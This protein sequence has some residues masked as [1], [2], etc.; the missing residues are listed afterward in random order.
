[1]SQLVH[2]FACLVALACLGH[3][4]AED[5]KSEEINGH[6]RDMIHSVSSAARRAIDGDVNDVRYAKRDRQ[7]LGFGGRCGGYNEWCSFWGTHCCDPMKCKYKNW[8]H[9]F[10]DTGGRCL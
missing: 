5:D 7:V 8:T 9:R 10:S 3:A 2:V 6:V 4:L 1:M